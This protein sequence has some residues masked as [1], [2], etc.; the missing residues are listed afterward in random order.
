[1]EGEPAVD[2]IRLKLQEQILYLQHEIRKRDEMLELSEYEDITS[3]GE[4]GEEELLED[5]EE[6]E[7]EKK[8][9]Q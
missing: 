2:P 1:M 4:E 9:T 5:E 6:D 3:N 8:L 7:L